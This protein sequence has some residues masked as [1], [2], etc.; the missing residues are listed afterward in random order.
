MEHSEC[1]MIME[2]SECWVIMEHSECWVIMEH[3]ECSH[4]HWISQ[5]EA[6]HLCHLTRQS[7]NEPEDERLDDNEHSECW[8]NIVVYG[9]VE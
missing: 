5:G 9:R 6:R 3:S 8:V 7:L 4:S 2:L 1:W